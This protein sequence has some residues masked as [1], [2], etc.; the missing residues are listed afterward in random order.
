MARKYTS[1]G[2]REGRKVSHYGVTLDSETPTTGVYNSNDI[3]WLSD[4]INDGIDLAWEEHTAECKGM[5]AS[6][7]CNHQGGRYGHRSES[8][9]D[10]DFGG[11]FG[12]NYS[13]KSRE[14]KYEPTDDHDGCGPEESGDTL[15]GSWKKVKGQYEPDKSGEY[16]AIYRADSYTVQVVWSRHTTHAPLAS[17]CYPGQC[18]ISPGRKEDPRYPNEQAAYAMPPDIMG[19]EEE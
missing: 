6:C 15:I 9:C 12:R 14:H 1:S 5:C 3:E 4:E 16:A 19:K 2:Y 13:A 18:S 8:G 10:C 11:Y 17:P 7:G